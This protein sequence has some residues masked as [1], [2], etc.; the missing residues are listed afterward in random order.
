MF[1]K[2]LV[3][4]LIPFFMPLALAVVLVNAVDFV[5]S[6]STE[7]SHTPNG[8]PFDEGTGE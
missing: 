2:I 7:D 1:K 6:E 4:T 3:I 5:L 8:M